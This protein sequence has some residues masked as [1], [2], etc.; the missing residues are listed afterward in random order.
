MIFIPIEERYS[1][2][3]GMFH[4]GAFAIAS[5]VVATG[6]AATSGIMG[7][8]SADRAAK[9]SAAAT[10]KY[11]KGQRK[12]ADMVSQVDTDIEAPQY[13]SQESARYVAE[14]LNQIEK[15]LP[16]ARAG[17]KQSIDALIAQTNR[18]SGIADIVE[19]QA[20]TGE[21]T[22]DQIAAL[23]R[24]SAEQYWATIPSGL[25]AQRSQFLSQGQSQYLRAL[26]L[27]SEGQRQA[28]IAAM[29]GITSQFG[30]LGNVQQ[31]WT[32]LA[33][34][35]ISQANQSQFAYQQAGMEAQRASAALKFQGIGLQSGTTQNIYESSL[36]QAETD[37]A[38][39]QAIA[40]T[41]QS[42]GSALSGGLQAYSGAMGQQQIAQ[43]MGGLRG[44]LQYA[45]GTVPRATAV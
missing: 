37:L 11:Q 5:A 39:R 34:G 15:I 7:A 2:N 8:V 35:F 27:T 17:R 29:P 26:G 16:G 23:Q 41:V 13:S 18:L 3:R 6:A 32:D 45:T 40:S 30:M 25:A 21:L 38:A 36:A 31:A 1:K 10:R 20:K 28:A 33:A 14:A 9:A 22:P 24:A 12:I 43:G 42:T 44:D 4:S 19:R